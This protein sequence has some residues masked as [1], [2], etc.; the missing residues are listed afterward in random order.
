[1]SATEIAYIREATDQEIGWYTVVIDNLPL[2]IGFRLQEEALEFCKRILGASTFTYE[3][4]RVV[5]TRFENMR[6]YRV[7]N[8]FVLDVD[9]KRF[10]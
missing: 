5:C 4:E 1:M 10:K 3:S 9:V 7:P 2:S 8:A 6:K